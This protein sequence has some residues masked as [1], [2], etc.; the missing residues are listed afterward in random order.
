M[1]KSIY[2]KEILE[3]R[4]IK[5]KF[6]AEKLGVTVS[7]VSLWVQEKTHPSIPNLKKLAEV[8]NVDVNL[9]I[10]GKKEWR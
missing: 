6:I 5:Q 1:E 2:L 4:G 10:N 8:L 7:S 3:E 9:I